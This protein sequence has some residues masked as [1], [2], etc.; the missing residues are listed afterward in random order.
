[1]SLIPYALVRPFLFN[2]D[3]EAAHDFTMN[4][5]ALGQG[6][7]GEVVGRFGVHTKQEGANEGVR[8]KRHRE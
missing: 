4:A 3:P 2:M 8:D 7:H 5:L 1:M 6:V